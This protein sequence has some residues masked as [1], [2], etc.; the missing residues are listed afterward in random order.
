MRKNSRFILIIVSIIIISLIACS[1]INVEKSRE[2]KIK[3]NFFSVLQTVNSPASWRNWKVSLKEACTKNPSTYTVTV[4]SA[5]GS[6]SIHCR[7]H[8]F[9]VHK[10]TPV[11]FEVKE[12]TGKDT[13]FYNIS[14]L[15][16][17]LP[18]YTNVVITTRVNL[19]NYLFS[20]PGKTRAF[21]T[22]TDLKS[23]MENPAAYYGYSFNI[24]ETI[25]TVVVV[26]EKIVAKKNW[27]MELSSLYKSLSSFIERNH[28]KIMQPKIVS[29]KS[30]SNDSVQ[31][32]AGIPVNHVAPEID[33]IKCLKMPKAHILVG[34][35][36]GVYNQRRSLSR[37][38]EKYIRNHSLD[39]IALPYEKYLD[40]TIP[41]TDTSVVRIKMYYPIL[42]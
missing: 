10:L 21:S 5:S 23:F 16:T 7:L 15:S 17:L 19:L 40:N 12:I 9:Y 6:F 28:L 2:I 22:A 13:L 25:D 42:N 14:I 39:E 29:F 11:S 8:S 20:S 36:N 27:R 1:F 35:Y 41:G 4:D 18:D 30:I 26:K 33:D 37:A 32:R 31:M 24:E 38:M 3:G 34:E